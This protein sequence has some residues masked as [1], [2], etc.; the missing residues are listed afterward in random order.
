MRE[1]KVSLQRSLSTSPGS[2]PQPVPDRKPSPGAKPVKEIVSELEARGGGGSPI[3]H[4]SGANSGEDS[5]QN[6]LAKQPSSGK[7]TEDPS[8]Q[9]ISTEP[10]FP[11]TNPSLEN[12]DRANKTSGDLL[13]TKEPA[14]TTVA[15]TES[16]QFPQQAAGI[17]ADATSS[18]QDPKPTQ[19]TEASS[20]GNKEPADTAVLST[21]LSQ[22]ETKDPPLSNEEATTKPSSEANV[23]PADKVNPDAQREQSTTS[24]PEE[25]KKQQE[26]SSQNK[27]NESPEPSALDKIEADLDKLPVAEQQ[28]VSASLSTVKSYPPELPLTRS[29]CFYWSDTSAASSSKSRNSS[30]KSYTSGM[31]DLF[32]ADNVPQL[33]GALKALKLRGRPQNGQLHLGDYGLH[34]P[35]QNIHVFRKVSLSVYVMLL[36]DRY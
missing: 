24:N 30:V 6:L 10:L 36:F 4:R 21:Q 28:R 35:G 25:Q 31:V 22:P 32:E 34:S 1:R 14:Q 5:H 13:D 8:A 26:D 7:D 18:S 29:W 23:I 9:A 15:P 27:S 3:K 11:T 33:C 12:P 19:Q 17:M 2:A 20:N 16:Q